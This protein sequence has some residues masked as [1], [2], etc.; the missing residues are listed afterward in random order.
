MFYLKSK[1]RFGFTM[2]PN[3]R[4]I[5][6]YCCSEEGPSFGNGFHDIYKANNPNSCFSSYSDLGLT[7]LHP[8]YGS[9]GASK[10]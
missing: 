7:Y 5:G 8:D 1:R 6:I 4:G 10:V 3:L 2:K 9:D